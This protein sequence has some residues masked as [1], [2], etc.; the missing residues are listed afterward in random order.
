M[1]PRILNLIHPDDLELV[2]FVVHWIIY[3]DDLPDQYGTI[4]NVSEV[5]SYYESYRYGS[6]D[7]VKHISIRC[8]PDR[9]KDCCG[10]LIS[11]FSD[12][13]DE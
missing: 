5:L 6:S 11:F 2:Q 9:L 13:R 4:L 8:N 12:E 7:R 1:K 10:C 3:A